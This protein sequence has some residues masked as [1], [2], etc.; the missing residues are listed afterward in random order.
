M[1]LSRLR[2]RLA[3]EESGFTLIELLVVL[4]IIAILLAI[5]VPSYLAFRDRANQRAASSNVRAAIP[6]AEMYYDANNQTYTGMTIVELQKYDPQ[7][8]LDGDP[9]VNAAGDTYCIDSKVADKVART[10]RGPGKT[11]GIE[12]SSCPATL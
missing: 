4:I 10:I 7:V 2:Q 12:E 9:V 1:L 11:G 3:R 6:S 5:A 8:K